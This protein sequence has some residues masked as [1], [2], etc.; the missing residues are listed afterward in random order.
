MTF[1]E[2]VGKKKNAIGRR[3]RSPDDE[4]K[5]RISDFSSPPPPA[6]KPRAIES[7]RDGIRVLCQIKSVDSG[8]NRGARGHPYHHETP[9][10]RE[11]IFKT[12]RRELEAEL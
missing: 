9:K 1:A 2:L 8:K 7:W 11:R 4:T 5:N 3:P 10:S 12:E 6:L